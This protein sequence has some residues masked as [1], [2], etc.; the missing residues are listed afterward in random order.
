VNSSVS[1]NTALSFGG[2]IFNTAGGTLTVAGTLMSNNTA[3]LDEGGGVTNNG[4]T[5]ILT[6]DTLWNNLAATAGGA[7]S[8]STSIT[9][10]NDTI[11]DNS[12]A[13]GPAAGIFTEDALIAN[14]TVADNTGG[15]GNCDGATLT[16][17]GYNLDTDGT[18]DFHAATDK[19]E[20]DPQLG[21]LQAN[22]GPTLTMAPASA[23]PVVNA[24]PP[25]VNGC[26]TTITTDQRGA[27]RPNGTGCDIGAYEYGDVA[28]Q[29]LRAA[30]SRVKRKHTL[31]YTATVSNA[32]AADATGV[33]VTDTL[34]V[35]ETEPAWDPRRLYTLEAR[36]EPWTG[37]RRHRRG[38]R[39]S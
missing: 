1:G 3:D 21:S 7:V 28:L 9:L 8:G 31:T 27:L 35:G 30:P 4:G 12:V 2:G 37:N 6:N 23:S 5:L 20:V 34:P 14:T 39:L 25:G 38:T 18:C 13:V 15:S 10:T 16:D 22:G 26:G 32:G 17:E 36:M 24:I 11:A 33:M 19:N 29:S